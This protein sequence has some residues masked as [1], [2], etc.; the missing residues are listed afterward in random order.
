MSSLAQD[1]DM[2]R[3]LSE[4]RDRAKKLREQS[5]YALKQ[6]DIKKKRFADKDKSPEDGG[7]DFKKWVIGNDT[8]EIALLVKVQNYRDISE[9]DNENNK[10]DASPESPHTP[11]TLHDLIY[12]DYALVEWYFKKKKKSK[13]EKLTAINLQQARAHVMRATL[14]TAYAKDNKNFSLIF[15]GPPGTGKTTLAESLALSANVPLLRLSPSD[16]IL[17]GQELI[18]GRARDVFEALS[19]LTQCVVIFDE[20]EPVLKSRGKDKSSAQEKL[21]DTSRELARISDALWNISE[22]DDPKFRF[23]LGGMLPKF[24]KLHDA[25]EKQSFAYCLGTNYLNDIDEAAKRPGRFDE[26]F[27]IYKPDVLSRAG[28]LLYRLSQTS[29]FSEAKVESENFYQVVKRFIEVVART[30]D[31]DA[32]QINK[33]FKVGK[34][35]IPEKTLQYIFNLTADLL[36]EFTKNEPHEKNEKVQE[37]LRQATDIDA[38]EKEER[39]W[40]I[41]YEENFVAAFG[42][43]DELVEKSGIVTALGVCLTPPTANSE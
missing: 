19:M 17:Q 2:L 23:V 12:S 42:K 8:V 41:D 21:R 29:Q 27:P 30:T 43:F 35:K 20:F 28:L 4:N 13:E 9:S 22:K 3:E 7:I 16:L 15:Y 1:L 25:V 5:L 24:I 32:N 11:L 14:P 36:E 34:D 39:Q 38:D 26:R 6:I 37:D 18:E 31:G 10:A 40:L 33:L